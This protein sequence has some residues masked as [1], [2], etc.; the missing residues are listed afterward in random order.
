MSRFWLGSVA[1]GA[2]RHAPVPILLVRPKGTS[3][4]LASKPLMIRRIR[5]PLDGL[6]LAETV[7]EPAIALGGLLGAEFTL[8]RAVQGDFLSLASRYRKLNELV[9]SQLASQRAD[10]QAYLDCIAE[11]LRAKVSRIDSR[12]VVA[13]SAVNAVLD[14]ACSETIDL[15]AIATHGHG[16]L[17][18]LL[19]G[20][21]TDKVVRGA[22]T[23]VL[24]Y[25][26]L[27][28][29]DNP[30]LLLLAPGNNAG[31]RKQRRKTDQRKHRPLPQR[32]RG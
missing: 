6:K 19:L 28:V 25:R 9:Q 13:A 32:S 18:R 31:V 4:D 7:L 12:V 27:P 21:V 24:T 1:D 15:I 3:A 11:R 2:V 14:M 22:S 8:L 29:L 17:K 30:G 5:I 23:P 26:P 16:G 10:A 20:S